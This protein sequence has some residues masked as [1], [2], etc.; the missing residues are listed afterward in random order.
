MNFIKLQGSIPMLIRV[1]Q[2]LCFTPLSV[3]CG[4]AKEPSAEPKRQ[5]N[6]HIP[7]FTD[8]ET[9]LNHLSEVQSELVPQLTGMDRPPSFSIEYRRSTDLAYTLTSICEDKVSEDKSHLQLVLD[10]IAQLEIGTIAG[11]DY[12]FP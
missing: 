1:I 9:E 10:L 12:A 3:H 7:D 5:I 4:F 2:Q 11:V 8:T 6:V